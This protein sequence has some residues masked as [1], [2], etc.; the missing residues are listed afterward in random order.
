[1]GKL[2]VD[3]IQKPGGSVFTLPS[4]AAAG[5]VKSDSSGNMII[6]NA[7]AAFAEGSATIGMIVSTTAQGNT[8]SGPS[9][10][11]DGPGGQLFQS[12][13]FGNTSGDAYSTYS[14]WNMLMGDGTPTGTSERL[15][16]NNR[17]GDNLR[18]PYYANNKRLGHYMA[19]QYYDNNTTD[20]YTG[21][22]MSVLPVRNTTSASITRTFQF[23]HSSDYSSYGGAALAVFTPTAGLYSAV[24]GG[25]W[26]QP[27]TYTSSS[28]Q[29]GGSGAVTIPA[30]STVLVVLSTSHNYDT[31]YRFTDCHYYYN[32]DT[33]IDGSSIICDTRMLEAC[34]TMRNIGNT[35][36][37]VVNMP[38]YYSYCATSFG[39]R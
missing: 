29:V 36:Y 1:M 27:Y 15:F 18:Q 6:G 5:F 14:G 19:R 21:I 38:G 30:N 31:T 13:Y 16:I 3:Q 23:Y 20:N 2:I 11:S 33:A 35:A 37:N 17:N 25:T 9:W 24:T 8:Y 7:Q 34:R 32:I 39:D 26:T 4:T 12:R 28:S 10:T 22:T